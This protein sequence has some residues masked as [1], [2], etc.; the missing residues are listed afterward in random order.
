MDVML[1]LKYFQRMFALFISKVLREIRQSR[2][3]ARGDT[4][5]HI[6]KRLMSDDEVFH[7]SKLAML[8]I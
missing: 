3:L 5:A 2:M 7:P 8:Y 1:S 6:K 4:Q